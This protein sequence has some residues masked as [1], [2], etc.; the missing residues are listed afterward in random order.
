MLYSHTHTSNSICGEGVSMCNI[1]LILCIRTTGFRSVG[2]KRRLQEGQSSVIAFGGRLKKMQK[3]PFI[4]FYSLLL[5]V[6][7]S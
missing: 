6:I 7:Y 2:W 4:D 1:L 5:F 3:S